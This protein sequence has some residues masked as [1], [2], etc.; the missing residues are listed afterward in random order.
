[1]SP[2]D[3]SRNTTGSSTL[4]FDSATSSVILGDGSSESITSVSG[5]LDEEARYIEESMKRDIA[6]SLGKGKVATQSQVGH[7]IM[8][9]CTVLYCTILCFTVHYTILHYTLLICT[10]PCCTTLYCTAL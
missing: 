8:L 9:D 1:V 6:A 5:E 3:P 4:D 2:I 7:C 10:I